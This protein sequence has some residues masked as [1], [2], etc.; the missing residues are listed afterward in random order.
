[1]ALR[2]LKALEKRLIKKPVLEAKVKDQVAEYERKG[3]AHRITPEEL[4]ATDSSKV[5]YL[6]LGVVQNPKKPDKLELIWDAR[7]QV[8][9]ISFNDML[10]KGPDLLVALMSVLLR[11]R[12]KNIAIVGD[13]REMFH[14]I[15][16]R[17]E[18]KQS[19]LFI[20]RQHPELAPQ[21]FVMDVAT[22]GATCSPISAPTAEVVINTG[23]TEAPNGVC[24]NLEKS[25]GSERVLSLIW[26]PTEDVFTFDLSNLKDE[27]KE[28]IE[29]TKTPTKR[30]VLRIYTAKFWRSGTDWDEPISEELLE[31]W[32]SWCE[33]MQR[34]GKVAVPRCIF[35]GMNISDLK[36][37]EAHL[38]VDASEVA[39]AAVLYLRYGNNGKPKCALVAAKT[40]PL[41]VPRLE[42]QTAMLGTRLMDSVL[43]S[44]DIR[45]TER[46]FGQ[47]RLLCSAGYGL[48][49]DPGEILTSTSLDEWHYVPSKLN[50]ADTATK[51]KDGP[52]FDPTNTW[53]TA[54]EF[55]REARDQ[56][57]L[58]PALNR[59]ETEA[60]LRSVFL[61]HGT[62]SEP[63]LDVSRF[64][65]WHR[66]L[67]AAAPLYRLSAFIDESGV[68]RM[69]SRIVAQPTVSYDTKFPILLPR[70]HPAVYLLT[71]SY[72][73]R[74]QHGNGETVCNKMRQRLHVSGLRVLIHRVSKQ[75]LICRVKKAVPHPPMMAALPETRVTGMI[76]P[77]THTGVDYFG[78]I[79]VKQGRCLVKRW[80]ALF[81]YLTVRAV[82]LEIVHSLSTQSCVMAIRRFV[83]RRGSP[84]TFYSDNGTNF[85]GASNLLA[86]Q[87]QDIH[88]DCAVTFTN[89]NTSSIFNPP[90]AP[91]MGGSWERM[92]Q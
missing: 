90:L 35:K 58:Q 70:K 26:S 42:L 13:I 20:F 12:Q 45:V 39:C 78:P 53:F 51:W 22:F 40:K 63:L 60:E 49:A 89:T 71:E 72:H 23:G 50:N 21:I 80:V 67:R 73:Q 69:N 81:T 66:L 6:P 5:W 64:S 87:I 88:E 62:V 16:I 79:L 4:Q 55:L 68:V 25:L 76:R 41:S 19:Q 83:A 56:W 47:I 8:G 92:V 74:Y 33:Y 2:R 24:M 36:D 44:L 54:P 17:E 31:K 75:C 27:I 38:F 28:L 34:L 59:T 14:Q 65:N 15:R 82:H 29:S 32:L 86:K 57:P 61:F 37:V 52:S 84:E 1:M 9:G 91:H 7:A 48:I 30:Q 11:F 85:L 3:Y 18:D 77:F 46:F 43:R 10:L